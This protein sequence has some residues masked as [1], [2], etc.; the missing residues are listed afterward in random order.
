MITCTLGQPSHLLLFVTGAASYYGL[1][2]V[3]LRALPDRVY[4]EVSV[5]LDKVA[6]YQK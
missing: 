6:P 5:T 2:E 4:L 3:L 1:P